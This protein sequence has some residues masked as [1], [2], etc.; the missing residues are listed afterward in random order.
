MREKK[1]LEQNFWLDVAN[2]VEPNGSLVARLISCGLD[3]NEERSLKRNLIDADILGH[4]LTTCVDS[5]SFF[6]SPP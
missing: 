3:T 5:F 4:F 2:L 1:R 6:Y